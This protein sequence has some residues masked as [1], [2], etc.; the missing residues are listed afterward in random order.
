MSSGWTRTE[1]RN[2]QSHIRRHEKL[3]YDIDKRLLA[4]EGLLNVDC[5]APGD[6]RI[7]QPEDGLRQVATEPR[8]PHHLP[9]CSTDY[10]GCSPNCTFE[11]DVMVRGAIDG[12]YA[13]GKQEAL[14]DVDDAAE[15]PCSC[16][17]CRE[18]RAEER[19]R[20]AKA[21]EE[22]GIYT[23]EETCPMDSARAMRAKAAGI[24]RGAAP[25]GPADDDWLS[26]LGVNQ[27]ERDADSPVVV[28][29]G[30]GVSVTQGI[31]A[32]EH[33]V[34]VEA[35]RREGANSVVED[36]FQQLQDEWGELTPDR[37][38]IGDLV[39]KFQNM[40]ERHRQ[41]PMEPMEPE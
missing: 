11:Y 8:D 26:D 34:A 14:R 37:G 20:V 31:P 38:I 22:A 36:L 12:A 41:E 16:K 21:I 19:E 2:I 9:A 18:A 6:L 5:S 4:V 39:A 28:R 27:V 25:A 1:A 3:I 29:I 17:R 32:E 13:L 30:G 33:Y 7:S 35:A 24:A 40:V 10:R 23:T 15:Q